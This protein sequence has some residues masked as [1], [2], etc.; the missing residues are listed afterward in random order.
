MRIGGGTM[1]E[2]RCI[3]LHTSFHTQFMLLSYLFINL[4][5][6]QQVVFLHLGLQ[7][8]LSVLFRLIK[9]LDS[10]S[11]SVK[12]SKCQGVLVVEIY[13]P[14]SC[15]VSHNTPLKEKLLFFL[16]GFTLYKSTE[17]HHFDQVYAKFVDRQMKCS[18]ERRQL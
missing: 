2:K 17:G 12:F 1:C 6:C 9:Y 16:D 3:K 11:H 13:Q 14:K 5:F 18:F 15:S 8:P 7:H 10:E 4:S